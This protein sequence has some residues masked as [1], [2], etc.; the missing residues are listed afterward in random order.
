MNCALIFA[1]G[2]GTRM[3][4]K[5]KPK[6]FLELH[7]KPIII[8]TLERFEQCKEIDEIVVACNSD[9]IDHLQELIHKFHIEKVVKI[10]PGGET[11]QISIRNGLHALYQRHADQEDTVVLIHDGVRPL[12]YPE[13][14]QENIRVVRKYGNCITTAP[15]T[16]TVLAKDAAGEATQ[17]IDRSRCCLARAPQSFY[18]K[19]IVQ[20]HQKLV[21]AGDPLVIDSAS[22][23][24][25]YGVKLHIIDGPMENIKIT[26]PSD[27]YIFRAIVD[28]QENSQIW[29]I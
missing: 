21:A 1:G 29:G 24:S 4:T 15:V 22:L 2:T 9:W 28:A 8:Y 5:G 19:D 25:S 17:T 14:I 3:N 26:T 7:G 10:V 11:G 12:I 13:T 16:E 27:F 18:L 6:Q 20:A 23:M